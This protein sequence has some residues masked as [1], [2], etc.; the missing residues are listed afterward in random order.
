MSS[1][2]SNVLLSKASMSSDSSHSSMGDPSKSQ[3]DSKEPPRQT[4]G[5]SRT[6][7]KSRKGLALEKGELIH[8]QTVDNSTPR[9]RRISR[10]AEPFEPVAPKSAK[11]PF[12]AE[13]S[14][15]T[16]SPR[17]PT[18]FGTDLST[19][20]LEDRSPSPDQGVGKL[21][22]QWQK[23]SA[24]ADSQPIFAGK[25]AGFVPKRVGIVHGDDGQGQ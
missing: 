10:K 5:L 13:I 21:I 25:R 19:S 8:T 11:A 14:T 1:G 16:T 15:P 3:S 9:P 12:E 18:L 23:K 17:K 4:V 6:P 7:T 24:E 20:K 2:S 22:D